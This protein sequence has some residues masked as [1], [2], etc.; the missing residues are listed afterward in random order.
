MSG[1]P[2]AWR[3]A[4]PGSARTQGWH[5]S[6]PTTCW[7]SG[8][9]PRSPASRS[10]LTC[11]PGRSRCRW[12]RRWPAAARLAGS[13]AAAD[14]PLSDDELLRAAGLVEKAGGRQWA[15][16]EAD[17]KLAL[18]GK[19]LS[20]TEMP[21]DVRAEFAGIAGFITARQW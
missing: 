16:A 3:W 21:D 20:E 1:P 13:C 12:S 4:W 14:G 6:S 2:R 19:C 5:S 18:A 7:A 9:R 15:E 10:T 11:A 8:A 17:A